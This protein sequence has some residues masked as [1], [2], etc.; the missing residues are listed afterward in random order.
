MPVAIMLSHFGLLRVAYEEEARGLDYKFGN[1][2]SSYITNKNARLRACFL[3]LDAYGCTVSDTLSALKSLRDVIMLPFS[4]QASD[5]TIQAQVAEILSR[6]D[7]PPADKEFLAFLSHHKVDAG[8]AARVFVDTARRLLEE[9]DTLN[10]ESTRSNSSTPDLMRRSTANLGEVARRGAGESGSTK[11]F[12]DSNDLTNLKKLIGHV[13]SSANHIVMLSRATL[14]RPYVLCELAYAFQQRKKIIC[15][16]VNWPNASDEVGGKS[17]SFPHHLEE[18]IT[19][20]EDV[21]YFQRARV[22]ESDMQYKPMHGAIQE[23]RKAAAPLLGCLRGYWAESLMPV[24]ASSPSAGPGNSSVPFAP[25]MDEAE[26]RAGHEEEK[27]LTPC[28]S[29]CA[30]SSTHAGSTMSSSTHAGNMIGNSMNGHGAP[31]Q[32]PRSQA[33]LAAMRRALS[34]VEASLAKG[35]RLDPQS[36]LQSELEEIGANPKKKSLIRDL[37]S[38]RSKGEKVGTGD[39]VLNA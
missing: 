26:G 36:A 17:F 8:D 34:R 6:F 14:E 4:P 11:I 18:A 23:M 28:S 24:S 21:A 15:V 2:A 13:G 30:G 10:R 5:T 22:I 27:I 38:G 29:T 31:R 37:M 33:E 25:L 3:T 35:T 32:T 19:D 20:W 12:L 7:A 16:I 1:A 39:A 9:P